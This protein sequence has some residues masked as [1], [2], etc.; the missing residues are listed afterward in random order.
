M[1]QE[2]AEGLL[3]GLAAG[4]R[5]GGPLRMAL[6]LTRC[7]LDT[8]GY[9][10]SAVLARYLGWY[11]S[12]GF[13][14]GPVAE[15]VFQQLLQGVPHAQAVQRLHRWTGDRTAGCNPAHRI[16]P[17]AAFAPIPDHALAEAARADAAL[18]HFD[19]LAGEVGAALALTCRALVRGVD[20]DEAVA[21]TRA[22]AEGPLARGGF[23][24]D[25]LRAAVHFVGGAQSFS[26]AL[27]ASIFFAGPAN[28]AP[29]LVGA[30]A[31]ARWGADQVLPEMLGHLGPIRQRVE[32]L[33]AELGAG[34]T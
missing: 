7:L 33:A 16:G 21:P 32:E 8:G 34:W 5:I 20:W 22:F 1:E 28:Y 3:L 19:P 26:E 10:Q 18:T 6:V 4:D 29:V 17:L 12:E 9:S 24:P 11:R 15:G 25:V 23:A 30:L 13:D 31:G 14:T 27:D 2:R